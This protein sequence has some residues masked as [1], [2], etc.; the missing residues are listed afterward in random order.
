MALALNNNSR[1]VIWSWQFCDNYFS[2]CYACS[3]RRGTL[4]LDSVGPASTS[5]PKN[6]HHG[7]IW[8]TFWSSQDRRFFECTELNQS[9]VPVTI[10]LLMKIKATCANTC[11]C[12]ILFSIIS[13]LS[14][15]EIEMSYL[16]VFLR[17]HRIP[18]TCGS[19][20]QYF[21]S[22]CAI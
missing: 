22:Q 5:W 10:S 20:Q 12:V 2:E 15:I 21:Q 16:S 3:S 6:L 14:Y 8:R 9:D 17:L 18:K 13:C 19:E 1:A 11:T 4:T 7:H